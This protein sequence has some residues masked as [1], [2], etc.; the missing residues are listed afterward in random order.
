[1]KKY[2]RK[3]TD[4]ISIKKLTEAINEFCIYG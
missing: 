2:T 1:M 3:G 4:M